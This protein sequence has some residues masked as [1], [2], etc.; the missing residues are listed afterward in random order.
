VKNVPGNVCPEPKVVARRV[1]RPGQ[2]LFHERI[3][4]GLRC[5][6]KNLKHLKQSRDGSV[7]IERLGSPL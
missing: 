5:S 4:Q 2:V 7:A 6:V 1:N 3:E